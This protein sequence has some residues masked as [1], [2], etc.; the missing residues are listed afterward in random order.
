M[1]DTRQALLDATRRCV[2]RRG[3]AATTARDITAEAGA[4]LAAIGYHF[5]S[6]DQLVADALLEELRDWLG[7]ALDVL[8]GPGD[9][10][11]RTV[12]AVQT[13]TTTYERHRDAAPAFL[14]AVAQAPMS[15]ALRAGLVDLWTELRR[16]LAADMAEMQE[17]GELP[18][19]IDPETM[20]AVLVA[21]AHGLVLYVTVD[22]DGPGLGDMA[23]QFA[24][25]LL[26]V[27]DA[28]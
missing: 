9:P 14:Q 2:G 16:V 26:A 27:R 23:T 15:D 1:T 24:S 10:A 4:N 7:P 8:S 25:L 13:L 12:L 19:W 17:R 20:A 22:E 11:T 5:G 21:V 18:V 3:L 28:G 6:K